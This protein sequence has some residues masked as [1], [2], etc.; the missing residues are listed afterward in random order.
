MERLIILNW[1]SCE[2]VIEDLFTVNFLISST[3]SH[4]ISTVYVTVVLLCLVKAL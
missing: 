1:C 3:I 2:Y 4:W